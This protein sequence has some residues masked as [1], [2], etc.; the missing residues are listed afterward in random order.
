MIKIDEFTF[1]TG[2]FDLNENHQ[3]TQIVHSKLFSIYNNV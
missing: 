1:Y 2:V 3:I